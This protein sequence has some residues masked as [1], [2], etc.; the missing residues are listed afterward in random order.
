MDTYWMIH[1]TGDGRFI[2]LMIILIL[3]LI[4]YMGTVYVITDDDSK[5]L[6]DRLKSFFCF[7]HSVCGVDQAKHSILHEELQLAWIPAWRQCLAGTLIALLNI[8]Y[9]SEQSETEAL[10]DSGCVSTLLAR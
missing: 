1:F 3:I 10:G 7:D 9:S 6:L 8:V 4:F 5:P 2:L